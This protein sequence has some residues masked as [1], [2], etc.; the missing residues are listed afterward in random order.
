MH[1]L[2]DFVDSLEH[3]PHMIRD[4]FTQLRELDLS[5]QTS[6]VSLEK[7]VQQLFLMAGEMSVDGREEVFQQ[8]RRAY[9]SSLQESEEKVRLA[10]EM[11]SEVRAQ[12]HM[13]GQELVKFQ[14]ELEADHPGITSLLH[15]RSLL[16]DDEARGEKTARPADGSRHKRRSHAGSGA[17]RLAPVGT[18]AEGA[19]L[20]TTSALQGRGPAGAGV[21]CAVAPDAAPASKQVVTA[22]SKRRHRRKGG[23]VPPSLGVTPDTGSGLN[24][25][26]GEGPVPG[27]PTYCSCNQVSYGNMVACDNE[28]CRVEWFH[29][30]CVGILAPPEGRWYCPECSS[31]AGGSSRA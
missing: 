14:A 7:Q 30:S 20:S 4:R 28:D 13:A 16:L 1:Y 17:R 12:L 18:V 29:Y 27:E 9:H 21:S 25:L 15:T 11:C 19:P 2:D 6:T 5:V 23:D 3:L 22:V 31:A 24:W 8:L 10:E 26:P